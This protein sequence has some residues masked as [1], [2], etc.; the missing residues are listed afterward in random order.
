MPP[1]DLRHL[2]AVARHLPF[3]VDDYD[4]ANAAFGRWRDGQGD[5]RDV[6]L[7]AYCYIQR[8][9]IV[10]FLRE[11]GAP[12]D[13]DQCI[14]HTVER[15]QRGLER[16][17]D[18]GKF[19][20]YV[21]VA[22]KHTLLNHRRDRRETAEIPERT[23]EADEPIVTDGLHA[24]H[25]IEEVLSEAPEALREVGRLRVLEAMEYPEIAERTGRALATV[26]TYA[27]RAVMYL[28]ENPRIRALYYSDVLPPGVLEASGDP[29]G[30][31]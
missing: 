26:R 10:R 1:D 2:D 12:S 29:E 23:L 31:E 22:C 8:Y 9:F 17:K 3:A 24:R 19:A 18:S 7:W 14:S 30:E 6:D 13:L 20:S 25:V 21:S 11:R 4:A 5:R 15:V 27:W 28:R 16:I